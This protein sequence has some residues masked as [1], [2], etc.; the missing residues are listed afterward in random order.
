MWTNAKSC[1]H[2]T[3]NIQDWLGLSII[4]E[5]GRHS[6]LLYNPWDLFDVD[7]DGRL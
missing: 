1:N 7:I 5:P 3:H 6:G 4:G 2:F